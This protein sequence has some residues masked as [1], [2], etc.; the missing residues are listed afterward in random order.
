MAGSKASPPGYD[1]WLPRE[2]VAD[3]NKRREYADWFQQ[4]TVFSGDIGETI[5]R[6]WRRALGILLGTRPRRAATIERNGLTV[7]LAA[8]AEAYPPA[9]FSARADSAALRV[10]L[11]GGSPVACLH[12]LF[13]LMRH[14]QLGRSLHGLDRREQP[15]FRMRMIN[16]WDNPVVEGSNTG[17]S[18]E[19]GF[20]GNSIFHW[21]D[22]GAPNPRVVDYCRALA[23]IGINHCVINNVNA[24]PGILRPDMIAGVAA[25]AEIFRAYGIRI[26]ISVNFGSPV[27][28]GELET[29]DPLDTSVRAWWAAR[30]AAIYRQIPDFGGFLVKANSERQP[31]PVDYGRDHHD[32]ANMLAAALKPFGGIC[33]WRA[34]VYEN[35]KGRGRHAYGQFRPL[36]GSFADN[37]IVQVKHGPVD[38]QPNEPVHPLFGQM[39]RTPLMLEFMIGQEYTGQAT[40]HY[41]WISQW[42]SVLDFDTHSGGQAG[43]TVEQV[44]AGDVHG[45]EACGVTGVSNIGDDPNWT[46][47][48]LS[49]CNLYGFGRL[50]WNPGLGEEDIYRE[51][52]GLTFSPD[53]RVGETVARI[54]SMSRPAYI[55]YTGAFGIQMQHCIM[56]FDPEPGRRR[57]LRFGEGSFGFDRT[58]EAPLAA[59]RHYAEPLA[60]RYADTFCCPEDW[61]LFFH[62]VPHDHRLRDGRLL[63]EAVVDEIEAGLR[64]ID[65]M[66]ALWE[67]LAP[68]IDSA[69]HEAIADQ[70]AAQRAH[71][72]RW[73]EVMG[74][75]LSERLAL[76]DSGQTA[77]PPKSSPAG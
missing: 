37:V 45:H 5:E 43:A 56:H 6:E 12:G 64:A 2:P 70:F 11:T 44:V 42:K 47:L 63:R 52:A 75:Y 66:A 48:F 29:A 7:R 73:A 16:H 13:F 38:F 24:Y 14:M 54:L 61:I 40:H 17:T 60:L 31:G 74:K 27:A 65:A 18:I 68:L 50:L 23:S 4:Y 59:A 67:S 19:R 1:L 22:L 49:Q 3:T 57:N 9:R 62:R 35:H 30:A 32:G 8:D 46:G 33:I 71:A 76:A 36:D 53:T 21:E 25:L 39:P 10:E 58:G 72:R 20:A 77:S 28:L 69:R 34:F 15:R 51:W 41:S 26:W 55:G